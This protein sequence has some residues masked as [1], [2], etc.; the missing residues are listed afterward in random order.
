MINTDLITTRSVSPSVS[1]SRQPG[2][3]NDPFSG[4]VPLTLNV[5]VQG[6]NV[7]ATREVGEPLFLSGTGSVWY[8]L[9]PTTASSVTVRARSFL[10]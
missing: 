5:A 4:A 7:F 8:L 6:T 9:A 3:A 2:P 10:L 1:R